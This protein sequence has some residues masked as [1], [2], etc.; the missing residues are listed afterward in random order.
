M[1]DNYLLDELMTEIQDM[2]DELQDLKDCAEGIENNIDGALI[3]YFSLEDMNNDERNA[4]I[5]DAEYITESSIW[6]GIKEVFDREKDNYC[7][8][9][10][11][12]DNVDEDDII[13]EYIDRFK[14][15]IIADYSFISDDEGYRYFKD[16]EAL[17]EFNNQD[18]EGED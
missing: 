15:S 2:I 6:E 16:E 17:E 18:S 4:G 7:I 11:C 10:L 8:R 5:D 14:E 13:S 3:G 1:F 12:N 9:E